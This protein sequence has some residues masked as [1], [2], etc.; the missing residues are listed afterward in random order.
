MSNVYPL[1]SDEQY[2]EQA[3]EWISKLDRGLSPTE[4]NE[5]EQWLIANKEHRRVLTKM[6]NLWGKMDVLNHLSDVVPHTP[7]HASK[8][9][10]QRWAVAA[11]IIFA[12]LFSIGAYQWSINQQNSLTAQHIY[13]ENVYA[14]K[15]G[16]HATFYLQD[17]TKVVLN[18][19]TQVKV[20]YTDKQRLFELVKGELHVTVAHNTKQPLSVY[21]GGKIIQAVGTAFNVQLQ[22]TGVELIVTDGKVLVADQSFDNSTPLTQQSV[23]LSHASLAV[24]KGEKVELSAQQPQIL[25]LKTSEIEV[26]LSWQKGELIFRGESL[27]DALKE[28]SRYTPYHFK[29]ADEQLKTLQIAG[30]FRTNDI[31]GLLTALEQNFA[32]EHQRVDGQTILLQAS[33][34]PQL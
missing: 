8:V 4:A 7:N 25:Q 6:A 33:H 13:S 17:K 22:D 31:E 20:T 9:S 15:V 12:S 5:L 10:G 2:I 3:S 24:S 19:N 27:A 26:D 30:L 21:A 16:E 29:V 18:T 11:S 32:I 34:Q 1:K 23:R 28:I 14:T